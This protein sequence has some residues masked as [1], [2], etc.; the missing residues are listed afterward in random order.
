M[1]IAEAFAD[2]RFDEAGEAGGLDSVAVGDEDDRLRAIVGAGAA[3]GGVRGGRL[4]RLRG[5]AAVLLLAAGE[6]LLEVGDQAR[7]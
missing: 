4:D 2:E 6:D 7:G 3:G 5:T 1:D